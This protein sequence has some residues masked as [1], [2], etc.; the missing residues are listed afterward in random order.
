MEEEHSW[1]KEQHVQMLR[2]RNMF[3][4]LEECRGIQS[5]WAIEN[6]RERVKRRGQGTR[7]ARAK[8]RRTIEAP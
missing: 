3:D 6:E 1:L 7:T 4:L 8:V 2:G 5:D